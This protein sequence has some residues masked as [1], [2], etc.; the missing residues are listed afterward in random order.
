MSAETTIEPEVQK[1]STEE[2][3]PLPRTFEEFNE[4]RKAG[5]MR[6]KQF[7][8]SGGRLAGV[9]C[10]FT[11]LEI[12]DAAHVS[13]VGLCGMSDETIPAAETVLPKNLCPLIKST[14]GFALTEKCPYT[15]FADMIV[16]ETTCDGKKKMYELL[17][18]LKN[19][20]VLH[21]PNSR[22]RSYEHDEWYE[23]LK[24]FKGYLEDFYGI[25]ITDDDLREA[26]RTRNRL[27]RALIKLYNLQ[28]SE[29]PAVRGT[30]MMSSLLAGSFNFDVHNFADRVEQLVNQR[31]AQAAEGKSEVSP[32]AKRILLTGC[33]SGGLINKVGKVIE[34]NG[35][36][37]VC[38]DDCSG[39][40]T[41][42]LL[43][44]EE[45]PDIL[46]AIAERYLNINCSV[47]TPNEGRM[48]NTLAMVEK[49][50]V[51]GVIDAVLQACHTFN[52]EAARMGRVMEEHG[53]PYMKL[54]TD[55][56]MGDSGQIETRIAAFIETL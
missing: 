38:L 43:V 22:S 36:V 16:G 1:S 30:E 9:L 24:R 8:E 34:A 48:E 21:L 39:E 11:P 45:A 26:A 54:E 40:R 53:V 49:Y 13:A 15:Y 14:Y 37:I 4:Q 32:S 12:L 3:E 27:R 41:N 2:L 6:V 42:K 10:S 28:T 56:S 5:F 23:E 33:P 35:G 31:A 55:Y 44:D 20:Y 7:K 25:T 52:I 19:T 51:D 46:R 17:G 47:M 50:H 29:P 18:D